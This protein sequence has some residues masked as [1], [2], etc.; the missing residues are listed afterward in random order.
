MLEKQNRGKELNEERAE[1][2]GEKLQEQ[3][4]NTEDEM[5]KSKEGEKSEGA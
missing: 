2:G 1:M 4:L 3:T 5:R